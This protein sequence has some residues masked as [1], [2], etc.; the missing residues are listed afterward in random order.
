MYEK[1]EGVSKDNYKAAELYRESAEQGNSNAQLNLGLLYA[2]NNDQFKAFYW[3]NKSAEQGNDN[4]QYALGL[5]YKYGDGVS[6][7]FSKS[8][9]WFRKSAKQ[10]NSNAIKSCIDLG[11]DW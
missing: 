10:G 8:I 4:A 1:G 3:F 7:D 6:I 11:I 9:E 5:M 2:K